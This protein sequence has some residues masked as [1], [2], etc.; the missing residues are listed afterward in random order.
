MQNRRAAGRKHRRTLLHT[1]QSAKQHKV[2]NVSI[3]C[4]C[5]C[6]TLTHAPASAYEMFTIAL[7]SVCARGCACVRVCA[8]NR[9]SVFQN[10]F[11][12]S[13]ENEEALCVIEHS[14][15]TNQRSEVTAARCYHSE[16]QKT[17]K[18]THTQFS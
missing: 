2:P 10:V 8:C 14:C 9:A 17:H 6:Y 12:I 4:M 13:A 3:V 1:L 11:Q 15:S 5:V 7:C 18:I 16:E